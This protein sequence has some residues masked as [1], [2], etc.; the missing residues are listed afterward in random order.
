MLFDATEIRC[1]G[2][3]PGCSGINPDLLN[4]S[5]NTYAPDQLEEKPEMMNYSGDIDS[6]RYDNGN[7]NVIKC[8]GDHWL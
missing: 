2:K 6:T 7:M 3:R 4:A 5:A 8:N 1:T